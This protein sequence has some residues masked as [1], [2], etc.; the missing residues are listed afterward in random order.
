MTG[1]Q[2]ALLSA[3]MDRLESL[4]VERETSEA[5]YHRT[6]SDIMVFPTASYDFRRSPWIATGR[7]DGLAPEVKESIALKLAEKG[8]ETRPVFFPLPEMPAFAEFRSLPYP[9]ASKISAEGIS[10]PTGAHVEEN[11]YQTINDVF[12]S[13]CA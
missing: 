10:L 13:H 2:A 8:I 1:I 4:W 9:K 7:I 11:V 6:I 12:R 3:Q 5:T